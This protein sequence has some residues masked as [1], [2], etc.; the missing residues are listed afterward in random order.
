M[1]TQKTQVRR[2]FSRSADSYDA[3]ATVQR[4]IA[5]RLLSALPPVSKP[6]RTLDA[7]CGTGHGLTLLKQ[8]WPES[9]LL[10]LD[11][12]L[13][14]LA[15][16]QG[17]DAG[18][19]VQRCCADVEAMP[20]AA[21]S[22]DLIWSNLTLQWCDPFRFAT[23]AARLLRPPGLLAVSTLGP[24]TFV[25]LRRAFAGIDN[26]QHTTQFNHANDIVAAIACAG[27]R[28]TVLHQDTL[29]RHHP[30]MR[31]LLAEV[32]DIGA[33]R[34]IGGGVRRSG[35][36]GKLVWRRFEDAI[37]EQRT[38]AGLPLSYETLLICAEK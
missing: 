2:A 11:F 17:D 32:R 18:L 19:H 30:D 14:M 28:L 21:A 27:L 35:L 38:P 16:V 23:E 9:E 7:G 22:F 5:G 26:Y 3:T 25:E 31:Q 12:A 1:S 13:P 8:R 20:F 33:N 36:M 37:E 15:K 4:E 29:I 6:Q 24:G 10:A 34:G